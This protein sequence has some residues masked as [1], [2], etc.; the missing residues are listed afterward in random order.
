MPWC[1]VCYIN[2]NLDFAAAN[3][4]SE[5]GWI[6]EWPD[7]RLP[8]VLVQMHASNQVRRVFLP[9][10]ARPPFFREFLQRC[11]DVARYAISLRDDVV[12]RLTLYVED[13]VLRHQ[14]ETRGRV[15]GARYEQEARK[16]RI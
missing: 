6:T 3:H 4:L 8:E 9:W 16:A 10:A 2:V 14:L 11:T 13:D 15:D 12:E 7:L 5:T 1:A